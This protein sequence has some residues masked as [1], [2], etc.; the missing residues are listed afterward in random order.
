MLEANLGN[1]TYIFFANVLQL[2]TKSR[3]TAE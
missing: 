2:A 3:S 1:Y